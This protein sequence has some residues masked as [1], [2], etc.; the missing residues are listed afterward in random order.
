MANAVHLAIHSALETANV[1]MDVSL[2][3]GANIQEE[4]M[5]RLEQTNVLIVIYTGIEKP[6]ISFSGF[7]LGYFAAL[8]RREENLKRRPMERLIVPLF[9]KAPPDPAQEWKGFG[10]GI[11]KEALRGTEEEFSDYLRREVNGHHE[12]VRFFHQLGGMAVGKADPGGDYLRAVREAAPQ[13]VI[14]MMSSIFRHLKHTVED[15]QRPQRRFIIR[16]H[17]DALK[18]KEELPGDAGII[19][20]GGGAAFGIFGL[21]SM[22]IDN[23]QDFLAGTAGH[24]FSASWRDAIE[25]VVFSSVRPTST[26]DNNQVIVSIDG[27][28]VYRIILTADT[29]YYDGRREFNLY[30][31]ETLSTAGE[32]DARTTKLLN[33]LDIICR[34]RFLFLEENSLFG[35]WVMSHAPAGRYAEIARRLV[36]ELNL[37]TRDAQAASLDDVVAW[38][39]LE[40]GKDLLEQ[41]GVAWASFDTPIRGKCSG[42]AILARKGDSGELR[43]EWKELTAILSEM[44]G[45]IQPLNTSL[46]QQMTSKLA[47]LVGG[48]GGS[49]LSR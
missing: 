48:A 2:G 28:Q 10:L 4:L 6:S 17:A 33:G 46:I 13:H 26:V 32:G 8:K 44:C 34:F 18:D 16:T 47:E 35:K 42:I 9:L 22:S 31:V 19:D 45:I 21:S 36:G 40:I 37:F 30:F 20:D 1:L 25:T 12:V 11:S 41:M 38:A 24:R 27:R 3:G 7:E 23:W 49:A 15:V 43:Q 29:R 39:S 5:G 14:T